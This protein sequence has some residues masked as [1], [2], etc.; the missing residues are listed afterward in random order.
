MEEKEISR[1]PLLGRAQVIKLNRLLYMKYHPSEIA[2]L[3]DVSV[4]TVRRSYLA[5]GCPFERDSTNRIWIIGTEFR[6]WALE[7]LA[8]RKRKN[9]EP[10]QEDQTYCLK[11][12]KRVKII[13]PTIEIS[14]QFLERVVS[15]CPE[16]GTL[17][18]RGRGR[19]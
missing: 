3:L 1:Q 14:N 4:D 19:K 6:E 2:D 7:V 10:M 11:C 8:K 16:C 15:K 13:N 12:N 17:C 9:T 18:N 5:A